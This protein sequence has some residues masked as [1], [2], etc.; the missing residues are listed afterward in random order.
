ML[1][2]RH[3]CRERRPECGPRRVIVGTEA[4]LSRF[5]QALPQHRRWAMRID[6]GEYAQ[7]RG[8]VEDS[9]LLRWIAHKVSKR[10]DMGEV[11]ARS[12]STWMKQWPWLLVL[13]G[14]DEVTEPAVRKRLI[15]QVTEFVTNAEADNCDVLVVLTTRPVGYTE[16]IA[17][18]HSSN[19]STLT[20]LNRTKLCATAPW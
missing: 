19:A 13:D 3:A 18:T 16:N 10:S 17:P 9:T 2:S 7:E 20:T 6:L 4:A 1:S 11:R 14:L 8:L 15:Q 12:L 5:G